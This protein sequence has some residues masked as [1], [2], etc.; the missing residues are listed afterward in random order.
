MLHRARTVTADVE[1]WSLRAGQLV[2][3]DEASMAGTFEL[4]ALT[5]QARNAG[6]KVL[7][8]GDWAQLS[9]VAAGGAFHLLVADRDDA[10]QLHD[11]RR[12]RHE[13]ERTASVDLRRGRPDAADTYTEHGRVQGGDRESMLDLLYQDWQH[14]IRDGKRSLMIASDSQTVLDLNNR[15]RADRVTA[16]EVSPTGSNQRADPL[17][18][19]A[20]SL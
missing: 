1:R 4:D 19:W 13:W 15:A 12:F 14:D 9:P 3:V 2:I 16:G 8:V 5:E 11:V 6:A 20:T 7:L 18:V 10:A 17:W